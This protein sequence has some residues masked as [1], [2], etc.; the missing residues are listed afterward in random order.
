MGSWKRSA[1]LRYAAC[2]THSAPSFTRSTRSRPRRTMR[3]ITKES[4]QRHGVADDP[5]RNAPSRGKRR[6]KSGERR[7]GTRN[8]PPPVKS[9]YSFVL[10]WTTIRQRFAGISSGC[11]LNPM[12]ICAGSKSGSDAGR[13]WFP[14][15]KMKSVENVPS[16]QSS[17]RTWTPGELDGLRRC[18]W[19]ARFFL[20]IFIKD[21]SLASS[22]TVSFQLSLARRGG[23]W[24]ELTI[25]SRTVLILG[26]VK[27]EFYIYHHKQV[28][29]RYINSLRAASLV[30]AQFQ[31]NST[32]IASIH[33]LPRSPSTLPINDL[34]RTPHS[35]EMISRIQLQAQYHLPPPRVL[36]WFVT[37][38]IGPAL[39]N[40]TRTK[41]THRGRHTER[42]KPDLTLARKLRGLTPV[43]LFEESPRVACASSTRMYG[44]G[45][46]KATLS[47]RETHATRPVAR[48]T[49]RILA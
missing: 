20:R 42:T 43:T 18:A 37:R 12:E 9:N 45:V 19:I 4:E 6:G 7:L 31:A 5:L 1:I 10:L 28:V 40:E 21:V 36:T 2:S 22:Q 17:S 26:R 8:D 34:S 16:C 24:I 32:V 33:P 38:R 44:G 49:H 29:Q 27:N 25:Y 23:D 3:N 14:I 15:Q 41:N 46:E 11:R 13:L 30:D 35:L 39:F 47:T 48:W